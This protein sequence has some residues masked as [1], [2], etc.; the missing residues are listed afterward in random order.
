MGRKTKEEE[1]KD[2][3]RAQG[4]D[5]DRLA[6]EQGTAMFEVPED[7]ED[8]VSEF[9]AA[10]Y[11]QMKLGDLKGVAL[12]TALKAIVQLG[13]QLKQKPAD[14]E[15]S[16]REIDEVL[17][18]AGLPAG[19]RVELGRLE[20]ERLRGRLSGLELLVARLEGEA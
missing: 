1:A 9:T 4:I 2:F 19:R 16:V 14:D 18:D 6:V 12:V 7:P 8:L 10:V 17:S 11:T 3:L 20:I 5:P 15:E 13:E